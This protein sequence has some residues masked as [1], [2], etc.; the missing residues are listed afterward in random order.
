MLNDK[1]PPSSKQ[2][3]AWWSNETK[4]SHV[5][6]HS[7]MDAG[8]K[9]DAVNFSEKNGLNNH[10]QER[11]VKMPDYNSLKEILGKSI[12]GVIVKENRHGEYPRMSLFL[13]FSDATYYEIYSDG[14]LD[15]AGGIDKGGMEH[16][17]QYLTGTKGPMKNVLDISLDDS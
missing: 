13:V 2:Y 6:A 4:G 17:R 1:L 7:W 15:F 12:K 9:V 14:S 5:Q 8:W 10:R 3:S 16:A 11:I